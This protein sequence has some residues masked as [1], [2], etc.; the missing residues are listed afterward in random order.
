MAPLNCRSARIRA[1]VVVSALLLS[2]CGS[3]NHTASVN[4]SSPPTSSAHLE[5][6]YCGAATTLHRVLTS[7]Y[8]GSALGTIGKWGFI[9]AAYRNL[10]DVAPPKLRTTHNRLA[11]AA[12]STSTA[13]R[14]LQT[15]RGAPRVNAALRRI[16]MAARVRFG[17]LEA[18]RKS[19]KAYVKKRCDL[20][21]P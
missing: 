6:S 8:P 11:S 14:K 2:A 5:H 4:S 19:V 17:K 15:V 10:A 18:E 16:N 12:E 7:N 9:A 3:S 13:L 1:G 20:S 21:L